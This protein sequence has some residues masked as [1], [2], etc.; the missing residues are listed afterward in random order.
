[1][2]Y[3]DFKNSLDFVKPDV[4]LQTRLKANVEGAQNKTK[5]SKKPDRQHKKTVAKE[6]VHI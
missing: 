5:K 1:M 2:K 4:H 6:G 3:D